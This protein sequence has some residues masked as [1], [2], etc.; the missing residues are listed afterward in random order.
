MGIGPV[1]GRVMLKIRR[2]ITAQPEF[3]FLTAGDDREG[4]SADF[5]VTARA[6]Q[7]RGVIRESPRPVLLRRDYDER[8]IWDA[9]GISNGVI[10]GRPPLGASAIEV[11]TALGVLHLRTLFPPPQESR[12]MLSRIDL[13]RPLAA[14][15]MAP[16]TITLRQHVGGRMTRSTIAGREGTLGSMEFVLAPA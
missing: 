3:H 4:A 8:A 11:V 14:D 12:W 9:A 5:L 1:D 10:T 15:E 7:V 6:R 16:V 2:K 13:E